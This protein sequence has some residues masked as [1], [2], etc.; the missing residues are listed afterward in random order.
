[1]IYLAKDTSVLLRIPMFMKLCLKT[2]L[3]DWPT[4]WKSWLNVPTVLFS[5][6]S[7]R[8]L[9]KQEKNG[10]L[11]CSFIRVS[12]AL[13]INTLLVFLDMELYLYQSH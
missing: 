7:I 10:Q 4:D 8:F 2:R 13:P 3:K 11:C 9:F 1:M 6:T 5:L 12:K